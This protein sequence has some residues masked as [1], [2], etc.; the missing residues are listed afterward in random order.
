MDTQAQSGLYFPRPPERQVYKVR[1]SDNGTQSLLV[2]GVSLGAHFET[3]RNAVPLS[4]A[5]VDC[6]V[7]ELQILR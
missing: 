3:R 7:S 5:W 4:V 1:R 6:Q 2:Q